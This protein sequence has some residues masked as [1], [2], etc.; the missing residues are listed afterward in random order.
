MPPPRSGAAAQPDP[1]KLEKL[2]EIA[3]SPGPMEVRIRAIVLLGRVLAPSDRGPVETL[4]ALASQTSEPDLAFHARRA[5]DDIQRRAASAAAAPKP[6]AAAPGDALA[7]LADEKDTAVL[8]PL[9]DAAVAS[10][11][12]EFLAVLLRRLRKETDVRVVSKLTKAIGGFGEESLFEEMCRYLE[13]PDARVRANTIEGLAHFKTE[14]RFK[15]VLPLLRDPDNRVRANAVRLL[16]DYRDGDPM[17]L[18]G[19]MLR[20][21]KVAYRSSALFVLSKFQTGQ[22]VE[23]VKGALGDAEPAV[24]VQAA[25]VLVELGQPEGLEPIA[26]RLASA[27]EE[28]SSLALAALRRLSE[29]VSEP[30][31]QRVD[32]QIDGWFAS[33]YS[34]P[35]EE[36]EGVAKKPGPADS[37][38]DRLMAQIDVLLDDEGPQGLAPEPVVEPVVEPVASAAAPVSVDSVAPTTPEAAAPARRLDETQPMLVS[39]GGTGF[40]GSGPAAKKAGAPARKAGKSPAGKASGKASAKSAAPGAAAEPPTLAAAEAP[41]REPPQVGPDL[42]APSAVPPRP[43]RSSQS[44]Q[45]S[46]VEGH[47]GPRFE[48]VPS[49]LDSLAPAELKERLDAL[50]P[51]GS[52]EDRAL[53]DAAA[54]SPVTDVRMEA[55]RRLQKLARPASPVSAVFSTRKKLAVA[56]AVGVLLAACAGAYLWLHRREAALARPPGA[57][58]V[59]IPPAP[60]PPV[61]V[62]PVVQP[63][64]PPAAHP[65]PPPAAH[66]PAPPPPVKPPPAPVPPPPATTPSTATRALVSDS[67]FSAFAPFKGQNAYLLELSHSPARPSSAPIA[68]APALNLAAAVPGKTALKQLTSDGLSSRA[69]VTPDGQRIGFLRGRSG[70][71]DFVVMLADGRDLRAM[72]QGASCSAFSFSPG[73]NKAA[74]RIDN[75]D[76]S[77]KVLASNV[78]VL[79]LLA[80]L[81]ITARDLFLGRG[82]KY[83]TTD[84]KA[85]SPQWHPKQ[86]KVAWATPPEQSPGVVSWAATDGSGR[87]DIAVKG[88]VSR[89]AFSPG[90]R[91]LAALVEDSDGSHLRVREF[92][93]GKDWQDLFVPADPARYVTDFAWADSEDRL[94]VVLARQA[95]APGRLIVLLLPNGA[96][97]LDV[98]A[99]EAHT[100]ACFG[101]GGK[102]VLARRLAQA[103][104]ASLVEYSLP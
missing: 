104:L 83:L 76:E 51:A 32:A 72:T 7:K 18:L 94:V 50:D 85:A 40:T 14:E 8:F 69:A 26:R 4:R 12:P 63:P 49:P 81:P 30:L 91:Y 86:A 87:L 78:A 82:G 3:R 55:K 47:V 90:G 38:E 35:S 74:V 68:W 65:P 41:R 2:A 20:S 80:T 16:R 57:E 25:E 89:L 102:T 62:P 103:P 100:A 19:E 28:E 64:P 95:G 9:V 13:Y 52:T 75:A 43:A 39:D 73:G 22:A 45:A 27:N 24:A 59:G 1:V 97:R 70:C 61:P 88:R 36:G 79:D 29:R 77:G 48:G 31:K 46:E 54:K 56:A 42:P 33:R 93:A 99:D 101:P 37:A 67:P 66:P 44:S 34:I 60:L 5:L 84:G 10:P 11:R 15:R 58:G 6:V 71:G 17:Q 21:E 23:L 96:T 53:L 92:P 98:S